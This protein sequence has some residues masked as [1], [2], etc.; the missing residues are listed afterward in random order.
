MVLREAGL[1]RPEKTVFDCPDP[2]SLALFYAELLGV[3]L[4]EDSGDWVVIGHAPG[5][6]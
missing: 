4:T 6:A 5:R 1:A 2:R 3:K